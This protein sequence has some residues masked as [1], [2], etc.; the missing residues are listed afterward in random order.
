MR[1]PVRPQPAAT[2]G[3][4][5]PV[6]QPGQVRGPS[7]SSARRTVVRIGATSSSSTRSRS[8]TNCSTSP[9]RRALPSSYGWKN[10]TSR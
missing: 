9:A 1:S 7:A 3:R 8:S 5:D 10:A 2:G 6:D 4:R